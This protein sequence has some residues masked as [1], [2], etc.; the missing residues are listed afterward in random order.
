MGRKKQ[1]ASQAEAWDKVVA[2]HERATKLA[3]G[4]D[5]DEPF[6]EPHWV[7]GFTLWVDHEGNPEWPTFLA[8]DAVASQFKAA[9]D[10]ANSV[11]EN[12]TPQDTDT[13][14]T[15]ETESN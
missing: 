15:N 7:A 2:M 5:P 12:I 4:Y 1:E 9:K 14:N 8:D 3:C 10:S 11:P 13:L 6:P